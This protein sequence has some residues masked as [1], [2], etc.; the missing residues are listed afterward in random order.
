MSQTGSYITALVWET[1]DS[2]GPTRSEY[3]INWNAMDGH[4]HD[5]RTTGRGVRGIQTTSTPTQTGDIEITGDTLQWWGATS[6]AVIS[7]VTASSVTPS[8]TL[9]GPAALA[10][11]RFCGILSASGAPTAG[12]WKLWDFGYDEAGGAFLCTV[13]GSPGTWIRIGPKLLGK[14]LATTNQNITNAVSPGTD[15]TGL[16]VTATPN[17]VGDVRVSVCMPAVDMASAATRLVTTVIQ[18]DGAI[19]QS[20]GVTVSSTDPESISFSYIDSAPTNAAHTYKASVFLDVAG[21]VNFQTIA[22]YATLT[23]QNSITVEQMN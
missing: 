11:S 3:Q 10:N 19:V 1:L 17:G 5:N 15:I 6:S 23:V 8:I 9:S 13:A 14:G 4:Q 21:A 7:A 20:S 22:S 16:S 18:K 12:T 2:E